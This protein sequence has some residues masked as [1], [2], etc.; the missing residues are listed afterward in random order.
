MRL[1]C[2]SNLHLGRRIAGL[3]GHVG[4]DPA[5]LSASATWSRLADLA[6]SHRVDAVILAGDRIDRENPLFEPAG[7]LQQGLGLLER[8]GIPVIAITGDHDA[9]TL[10]RVA[11]L[12][13]SANLHVLDDD[14]PSI[15]IGP[16]GERVTV[17]ID[18]DTGSDRRRVVLLHASLTDGHAPDGTYAPIQ[19]ADIATSDTVLWVLGAQREPDVV[20]LDASTVIE[21]GAAWPMSPEEPGIHGAILVDLADADDGSVTCDIVPLAPVQFADIDLDLSGLDDLEAVESAVT[22]AVTAA[23]DDALATDTT[24]SLAAVVCSAH[25]FGTTR[26]HAEL[27]SLTEDLARTLAVQHNGVIATIGEMEIDTRPDVD[28]TSLMGRPDPVGELA[29]LLEALDD[30]ADRTP[31]QEALI[32]RATDRLVGVHRSRVFAGVAHDAAPGT[33]MARI[34]LRREAWNVLDALV[35]QRGI[36]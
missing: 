9:S 13:R 25:L 34:I 1:L 21:P 14:Q 7:A 3:P 26:W 2:A 23:L 5:R 27:P 29:R 22:E 35:R 36:D 10:P 15:D 6:V 30:D 32:Q 12:L 8:E 19:A 11:A 18:P 31:A 16:D 24:G 28:L 20:V 4:L 33:E 17:T